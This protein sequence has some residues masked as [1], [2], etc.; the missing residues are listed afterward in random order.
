M[1]PLDEKELSQL[2]QRWEAP[3]APPGLRKKLG[4]PQPTFWRWLMTGSIR[5]PVP[6]GLAAIV[7]LAL[8][9]LAGE[10]PPSPIAQPPASINLADFQPV[11]QLDPQIV[12]RN[13]NGV[14]KRIEKER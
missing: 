12:E 3:G 11:R 13:E 14:W 10:T 6:V 4:A 2:L 8:W 9:M 5:I 1:E 7:L